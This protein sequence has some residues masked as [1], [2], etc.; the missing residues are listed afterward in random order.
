MTSRPPLFF[1]ALLLA[2]SPL[3]S[4]AQTTAPVPSGVTVLTQALNTSGAA[5]PLNPVRSFTASGTITYF[6]AGKQIQAPAT[7][8]A[9][10]RDQFRVDATLPTGTRSTAINGDSGAR[11]DES[12]KLTP[13]PIHNTLSMG[14][15]SFPY[16][17]MAAVLSDPAFTVS[18]LGL[19]QSGA[20]QLHQVRV[21]R[22]VSLKQ[23]PSGLLTKLSQ[24][25]YFIDSQT[26]LVV[27]TADL[28]HPIETAT[29][30][31]PREM[32]LDGY[33]AMNGV[34]VPTIVREKI[35]GQT[36]W[37]FHL[38]TITFNPNLTDTDFSVQ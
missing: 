30:D 23:D 25:D 7:V 9:R 5:N 1:P 31:Y 4:L 24:T 19:V 27:K 34:T 26:N 2:L 15:S 18:Y 29:R 16:L 3:S 38:S 13:V 36:M 37:E 14:G 22:N 11:K 28:T 17:S 8:R 10:G 20:R 32:E 35:N 21:A 6:W 12:G 33:T